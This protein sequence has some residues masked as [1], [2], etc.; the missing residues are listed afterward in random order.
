[1]K[2]TKFGHCCLLIETNGLRIL[3]DPGDYTTGQNIVTGVDVILITHEHSDHL[4]IPSLKVVLQNNP[5]VKV[6]TNFAV[7]K[8]LDKEGMVCTL[9]E[10]GQNITINGVLLE[11][12]GTEHH[13]IYE[14]VPVPM[15][16]GYFIDNKL[17]YPG[18]N[19]TD[20]GKKVE[21][22]ALPVL[23][24]WLKPVEAIDYAKKIKPEVCFPVHDAFLKITGG[25]YKLPEKILESAGI[26][27]V[28]LEIEQETEFK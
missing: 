26:K 25:F 21:V 12:F 23:A 8:L 4:H 3:T 28:P 2:I 17:F 20:P 5:Q 18:D 22:L 7:G 9:L 14:G 16:T 15:N 24:P 13:F 6:I 11:A 10:D 19:L 27:F 1:M